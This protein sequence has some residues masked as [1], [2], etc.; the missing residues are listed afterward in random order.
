MIHDNIDFFGAVELTERLGGFQLQRIP[1]KVRNRL[2]PRGRWNSQQTNGLEIRFVCDSPQI[3]LFLSSIEGDADVL[4]YCGDFLHST[5][6]LAPGGPYR[7][8]VETPEKF[9]QVRYEALTGKSFSPLVW[10]FVLPSCRTIFHELETFGAS[11]RPPEK[12]EKPTLTWLAYGSS[13]TA[14]CGASRN[15]LGYVSL[16][17]RMLGVD[18]INLAMGG[19]CHCE[20]ELADFIAERGDWDFATFELGVNMRDTFTEDEF[21]NRAGYLIKTTLEKNPGKPVFLITSFPNQQDH[22]T[23]ES[24]LGQRQRK[25]NDI[26][27]GIAANNSPKHLHLL[28]GHE[29]MTD[30]RDL[31]VDLIHPSASGHVQMAAR[32]AEKLSYSLKNKITKRI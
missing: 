17:A 8:R 13:I 21:H 22:E 14:G 32:L 3:Q 26:L 20:P 29:I 18:V 27:R 30:F 25:F 24:V 11:V 1:E 9:P 12:S 15:D 4:V 6:L 19:A 7:I 10:R 5:H 2:N 16:A 23:I 28:E 31:L